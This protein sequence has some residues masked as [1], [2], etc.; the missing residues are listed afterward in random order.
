MK[1]LFKSLATMVP[2]Y[3]QFIQQKFIPLTKPFTKSP[4]P[5]AV[6][7]LSKSKPVLLAE[8][9]FLR[10]QLPALNRQVK[11]P[12]FNPKN[13]FRLAI[14]ASLVSNWKNFTYPQTRNP[15]GLVQARL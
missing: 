5:G 2:K 4:L 7:D 13:C 8:N 11:H 10:Q 12:K 14:L 1:G 9:A 15:A 6:M 3:G